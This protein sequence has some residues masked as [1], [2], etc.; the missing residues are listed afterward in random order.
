[1]FAVAFSQFKKIAKKIFFA[2][3]HR[4]KNALPG[5][6]KNSREPSKMAATPEHI[7]FEGHIAL[8]R[9]AYG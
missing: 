2:A 8:A 3:R 1:L 4:R 6:A 9:S 5:L 7:F